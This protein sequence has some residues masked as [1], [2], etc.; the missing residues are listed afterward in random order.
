MAT[1][2]PGSTVPPALEALTR[3]CLAKAPEDRWQDADALLDALEAARVGL[4][5]PLTP[6]PSVPTEV[7]LA[8]PARRPAPKRRSPLMLAVLSV[9]GFATLA[10]AGLSYEVG[11]AGSVVT[12][13]PPPAAVA[14]PPPTVTFAPTD[15]STVEVEP[16]EREMWLLLSSEPA[17]AEVSLDGASLGTTPL[18]RKVTI[19]P[20]ARTRSFTVRR[21]GYAEELVELDVTG[22]EATAVE[23]DSTLCLS[24]YLLALALALAYPLYPSVED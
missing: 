5:D 17:G 12:P 2:V 19:V 14:A 13:P 8:T 23:E 21:A 20:G 11:A 15:L 24:F 4:V 16:A 9:L 7:T 1:R 18:A 3:R 10:V 22:E 6:P